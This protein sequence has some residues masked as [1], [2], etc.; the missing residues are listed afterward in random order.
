MPNALAPLAPRT[1]ADGTARPRFEVLARQRSRLSPVCATR[2]SCP[3]QRQT[4]RLQRSRSAVPCVWR[5]EYG[6]SDP[7]SVKSKFNTQSRQE[8]E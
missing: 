4:R 6:A 7:L 1:L 5:R 3:V 8:V 2:G